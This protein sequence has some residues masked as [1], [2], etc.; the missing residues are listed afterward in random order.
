MLSALAQFSGGLGVGWGELNDIATWKEVSSGIPFSSHLGSP[1]TC[2]EGKIQ[3]EN[4]DCS[5]G[6]LGMVE[7]T[8]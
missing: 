3:M 8:W 1:L 5:L 7:D 6:S 2:V 4:V